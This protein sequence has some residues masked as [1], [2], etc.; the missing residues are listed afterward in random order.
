MAPIRNAR[1]LYLNHPSTYIVPGDT[2]L[3]DVSPTIDI[4]N[5]PLN[6]GFLLQSIVLS[7]DPVIRTRMHPPEAKDFLPPLTIGK[8]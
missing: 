3:F 5:V 2:T 6:G 4:D 7:S 8:P 1:V